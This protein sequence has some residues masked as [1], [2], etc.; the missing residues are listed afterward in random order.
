MQC[1]DDDGDDD[2]RKKKGERGAREFVQVCVYLHMMIG[3]KHVCAI[4]EVTATTTT[5]SIIIISIITT[6][7]IAPTPAPA[8]LHGQATT[9]RQPFSP[10]PE[11][12]VM[13]RY[14]TVGTPN[15]TE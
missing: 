9:R 12:V 11:K 1:D 4:V 5:S 15:V 8:A 2:A 13:E 14:F 7:R 3:C 10:L 6:T